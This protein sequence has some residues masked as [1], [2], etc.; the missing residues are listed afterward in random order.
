MQQLVDPYQYSGLVWFGCL[1]FLQRDTS[2][3]AAV[4]HYG[5]PLPQEDKIYMYLHTPTN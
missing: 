1:T 4:W 2:V 5:L 3:V